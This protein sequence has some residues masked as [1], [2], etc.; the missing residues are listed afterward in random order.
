M[1]Y[2]PNKLPPNSKGGKKPKSPEKNDQPSPRNTDLEKLISTI[3]PN[4]TSILNPVSGKGSRSH[5]F[6]KLA[7]TRRKSEFGVNTLKLLLVEPHF[8]FTYWEITDKS[9]LD[10]GQSIGTE[11]KLALRY[12][13][14]TESVELGNC[15]YWDI[16]I[17]DRIGK[18]YLRLEKPNQRLHLEIGLRD[19][20][21]VFTKIASADFLFMPKEVTANPGP[22]KWVIAE[23]GSMPCARPDD[24]AQHTDA[25][26]EILKRIMGPYFFDILM[27][28]HFPSI[29]NSS[30][31]ALFPIISEPASK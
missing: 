10:A 23:S 15:R 9:I 27:K 22:H 28:G 17:F 7:S 12:Y 29:I 4:S 25:D 5:S 26:P 8:L 20:S 11:A 13:D 2:K 6:H 31:E 14:I 3:S 21:K 30:T 19:K 16:E 18:W 24:N 1:V